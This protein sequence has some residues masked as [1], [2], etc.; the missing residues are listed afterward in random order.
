MA[1]SKGKPQNINHDTAAFASRIPQNLGWLRPPE[2]AI[3]N[4]RKPPSFICSIC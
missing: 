4:F 3:I 2:P 1:M